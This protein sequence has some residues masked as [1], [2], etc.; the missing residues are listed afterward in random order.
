M[1]EPTQNLFV[2]ELSWTI[3]IYIKRERKFFLLAVDSVFKI[4]N[5][6]GSM[7]FKCL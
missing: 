7:Q 6:L 3:C 4:L 1:F 5:I 2:E